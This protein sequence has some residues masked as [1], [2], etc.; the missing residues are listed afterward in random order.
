MRKAAATFA[1]AAFVSAPAAWAQ[2]KPDAVDLIA[3]PAAVLGAILAEFGGGGR[4][5]LGTYLL[6]SL[7]RAD[8]PRLWGIGL[9]A[10][11][12][13]GLAYAALAII[14]RSILGR[15]LAVTIPTS[16]PPARTKRPA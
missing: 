14:G 16:A 13:A 5:G 2:D 15:S 4:F 7:G 6:G 11:L 1:F 8:P 12:I 9:M 10:T 3:A